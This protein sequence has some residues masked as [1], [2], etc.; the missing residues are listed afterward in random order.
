M[1]TRG[2]KRNVDEAQ[3]KT[4]NR[5]KSSWVDQAGDSTNI[6]MDKNAK[7]AAPS[8]EKPLITRPELAPQHAIHEAIIKALCSDEIRNTIVNAI[9][10]LA[11][12]SVYAAISLDLEQSQQTNAVT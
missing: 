8:A 4:D 10:E 5:S 2:Q 11:T 3:V 6:T 1:L 9:V 7:P 12:L